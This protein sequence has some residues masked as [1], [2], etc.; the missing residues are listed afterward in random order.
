M[1]KNMEKLNLLLILLLSFFVLHLY[2]ARNSQEKINTPKVEKKTN[3]LLPSEH[4]LSANSKKIDR[5]HV[6]YA[7]DRCNVITAQ[8]LSQFSFSKIFALLPLYWSDGSGIIFN[9]NPG[10]F[11]YKD[12]AIEHLDY[13]VSSPTVPDREGS[14]KSNQVLLYL[15]PPPTYPSLRDSRLT[16]YPIQ[17]ISL[18][19]PKHNN[20]GTY[21]NEE[22]IP[23][24]PVNPKSTANRE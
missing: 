1:D 19:V 4:K 23:I 20:S 10:E 5:Q 13:Q 21:S 22:P 7:L 17:N 11:V 2:S 12:Q 9:H 15:F 8:S 6:S 24:K 16:I 14:L 3:A 18:Q